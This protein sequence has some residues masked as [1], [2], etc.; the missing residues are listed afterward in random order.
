MTK[1]TRMYRWQRGPAQSASPAGSAYSM[2]Q[3]DSSRLTPSVSLL[4][5]ARLVAVPYATR[6][7]ATLIGEFMICCGGSGLL[8]CRHSWSFI[9]SWSL[10]Y[11]W[12]C[13]LKS[14]PLLLLQ[15]FPTLNPNDFSHTISKWV[16]RLKLGCRCSSA[17]VKKALIFLFFGYDQFLVFG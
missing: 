1:H 3:Y 4:S 13:T 14:T 11:F 7:N 6:Y 15:G 10:L 16:C 2:S 17:G 9:F 8:G 12:S 5:F